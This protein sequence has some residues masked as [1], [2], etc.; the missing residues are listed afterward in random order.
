M[1]DFFIYGKITKIQ[2]N[3]RGFGDRKITAL[4]YAREL[5][6]RFIFAKF[7]KFKKVKN[8]L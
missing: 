2:A 5:G 8:G 3:P 4:F 7:G 1:T 6:K